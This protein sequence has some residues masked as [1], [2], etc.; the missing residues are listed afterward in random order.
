M[1]SFTTRCVFCNE[2]TWA[3][4]Y[5]NGKPFVCG[6]GNNPMPVKNVGRCCDKCNTTVVIPA[7]LEAMNE[8]TAV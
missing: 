6:L 8:S 7:R 2:L 5:K 3:I 1:S 4:R